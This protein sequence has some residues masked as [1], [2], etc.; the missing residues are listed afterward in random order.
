MKI[1]K[2]LELTDCPQQQ[3]ESFAQEFCGAFE[4]VLAY[5]ITRIENVAAIRQDGLQAR[6]YDSGR[7]ER[8]A[9]VYMFLD[10]RDANGANAD[11]LG[12]GSDYAVI[13]IRLPRQAII[14]A[15][16]YDGHYNMSAPAYSAVQHRGNVPAEWITEI[17]QTA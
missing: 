11:N 3:R 1:S 10:P 7:G 16:Y 14:E 5:H 8:L 9:A 17:R 6:V 12:Y 15:A 2:L 4:S 13:Q